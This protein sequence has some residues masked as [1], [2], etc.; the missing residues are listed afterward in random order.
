MFRH[1]IQYLYFRREIPETFGC[2][3]AVVPS[4]SYRPDVRPYRISIG[5][6][7]RT[8]EFLKERS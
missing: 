4:R 6:V 5:D 3:M 7:R 1:R 2:V 8:L